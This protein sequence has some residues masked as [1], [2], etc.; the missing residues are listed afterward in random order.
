MNPFA[1]AFATKGNSGRLNMW[2]F[3]LEQV[4]VGKLVAKSLLD[5]QKCRRA[6]SLTPS[7]KQSLRYVISPGE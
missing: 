7:T 1:S 4:P 3:E 5:E 6:E 2:S